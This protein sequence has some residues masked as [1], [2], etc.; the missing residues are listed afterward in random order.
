LKEKE[1]NLE[2]LASQSLDKEIKCEDELELKTMF[3]D[4]K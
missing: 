2:S 3:E 4:L 1:V